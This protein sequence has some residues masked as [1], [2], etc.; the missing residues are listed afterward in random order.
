MNVEG[1]MESEREHK[2]LLAMAQQWL[3]INYGKNVAEARATHKPQSSRWFHVAA[4]V[5]LQPRYITIY[6]CIDNPFGHRR[7][8]EIRGD[9]LW[10]N[11]G[12][13][14]RRKTRWLR[15]KRR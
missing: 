13:V 10:D 8:V 3:D 1:L 12:G 11:L 9:K 5:F 6:E 4:P 2:A 15:R 7:S 14:M